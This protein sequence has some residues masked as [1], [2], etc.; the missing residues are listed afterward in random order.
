MESISLSET[1]ENLNLSPVQTT[2]QT[3]SEITTLHLQQP[4]ENAIS[5][6]QKTIRYL[7][8]QRQEL[9]TTTK[10]LNNYLTQL[11]SSTTTKSLKRSK[12]D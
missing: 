11:L 7:Q 3:L 5:T 10:V 6:L 2:D 8:I 12:T 1:S 9:D 4:N